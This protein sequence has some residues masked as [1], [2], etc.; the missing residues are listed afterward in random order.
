M[1]KIPMEAIKPIKVATIEDKTAIRMV[2]VQAD[3]I[4][5]VLKQFHI[6]F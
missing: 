2:V 3:I 6:P 5:P 4:L 1:L